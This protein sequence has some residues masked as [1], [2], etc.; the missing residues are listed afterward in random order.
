M[1][2]VSTPRPLRVL[3]TRPDHL[4]DVLLALPAAAA[5]KATFPEAYLCYAV[6][7]GLEAVPQHCPHVDETLVVP[8]PPPNAESDPPG[9]SSIRATQAERLRGRFDVALV[10]RPDDPWS[11]ALVEAAGIPVRI[12]FAQPRTRPFLTHVLPENGRLHVMSL[13]VDLAAATARLFSAAPTRDTHFDGCFVVTVGAHAEAEARL[14]GAGIE[15]CPVI[16]HPGSGWR[17]KNWPARSWG[18]LALRLQA[19]LGLTPVVVAGPEELALAHGVV[20]SSAGATRMLDGLSIGALA[21]L[22]QRSR[23]VIAT[24]NGPMHL[25]AMVGAPVVGLFGPGDPVM[26]RPPCPASRHRVVRTG[27]PCSPCGTLEKP[28][29]GAVVEP[30]CITGVTVESVLEAA[31]DLLVTSP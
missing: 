23:M 11:G 25:A 5:L 21:T 28:P 31:R 20:E 30:A 15:G 24:D 26:F 22:Q 6:S 9:W 8:F 17:L 13:G 12:G 18:G 27:L 14:R 4:G 29:C 10:H 3:L 7:P 16:L 2:V 1:E 19:E